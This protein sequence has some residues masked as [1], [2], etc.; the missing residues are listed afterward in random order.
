M[1][2]CHAGFQHGQHVCQ[3]ACRHTYHSVCW[4]RLQHDQ[5][6]PLLT[7]RLNCQH[8]R[9]IGSLIAVW[10]Y[11]DPSRP[12]QD[13]GS[14]RAPNLLESG[15]SVHSIY[16]PREVQKPVSVTTPRSLLTPRS[17]RAGPPASG[18]PTSSACG[19]LL[20]RGVMRERRLP[21]GVAL[22]AVRPRRMQARGR[23]TSETDRRGK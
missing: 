13:I 17:V 12:I 10:R 3:L 7:P 21:K 19:S 22:H 20:V 11:S 23:L 14:G 4:E 15:A 18:S 9:G 5:N 6:K 16:T 8:C 2:I 1:Y